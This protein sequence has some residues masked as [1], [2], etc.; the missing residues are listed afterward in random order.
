MRLHLAALRNRL[1]G[2]PQ[3][4]CHCQVCGRDPYARRGSARLPLSPSMRCCTIGREDR[5]SVQS[6]RIYRLLKAWMAYCS[7]GTAIAPKSGATMAGPAQHPLVLGRAGDWLRQW[8]EGGVVFA[9]ACLRSRGDGPR[10]T[11][12][13]PPPRTSR[14][15]RVAGEPIITGCLR[16][17]PQTT[18]HPTG[19]SRK[20]ARPCWALREQHN[21][22]AHTGIR[23]STNLGGLIRK[24]AGAGN[25]PEE[26]GAQ[27]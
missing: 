18:D 19:S 25:V 1:P 11:R 8:R 17:A 13:T 21:R 6:K 12:G 10:A 5:R 16:T 15:W 9:L 23:A 7:N 27:D 22:L 24:I 3:D 20:A 2:R 14:I 26:V 4:D